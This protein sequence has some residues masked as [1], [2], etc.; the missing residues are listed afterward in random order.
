MLN[1][2][3]S[4]GCLVFVFLLTTLGCTRVGVQ[5][6]GEP[7]PSGGPPPHAPAHGYRAKYKYH[8]Y[9]SSQ[10]YFDIDRRTYFYMEGAAWRMSV[11]LPDRLRVE[12]GGR[13]EIDMDSD[14][15]YT[16]FEHHKMKYPPG[17]GKKEHKRKW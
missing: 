12:L 11:S 17:H 15:P 1:S 2:R 16:E 4:M 9:P 6:G 13:V 7:T 5:V 14:R 3:F 10:V 8:Y